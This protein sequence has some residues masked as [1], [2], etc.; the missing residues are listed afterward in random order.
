MGGEPQRKVLRVDD[1]IAHEVG[2]RILRGGNE[3]EVAALDL[4]EVVLELG[5]ARY[6]VGALAAHQVGNVDLGVAVLLGLRGEHELR[7]RAVQ[8]REA[9]L[10]HREARPGEL[11]P[12]VEIEAEGRA[13]VDMVLQPQS[14]ICAALPQRRTSTLSSLD[15]P[16]GTSGRGML[17]M[18]RRNAFRFSCSAASGRLVAL[19]L[20]AETRDFRQH[21]GGVLALSLE[22]ADLLRERVALRLQLLGARLHLPALVLERANVASSK[23][24]PRRFRPAMTAGRSLRRSWMSS[25][26]AF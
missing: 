15:F 13:H 8:A 16:S 23:S 1:R 24:K 26:R 18:T 14:R 22:H 7:E 17:G 11:G 25:I 3:V 9:A 20:F 19:Q 6:A 12:R 5:E 21:R 2:H 4:E 10:H